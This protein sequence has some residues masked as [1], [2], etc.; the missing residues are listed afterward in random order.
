V[1]EESGAEVVLPVNK[2]EII[3]GRTDPV[4]GIHPEVDMT[5]HG[6][7]TGGVSR[8]HA[9]ITNDGGTWAITDLNSTNYTR[10]DG[11]KLDPS[12]A[13]PLHDGARI[14]L[15]RVAMVFRM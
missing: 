12:V 2:R 8:Q 11:V 15:G 13:R 9:R 6:G 5:P 3:I 14:Q 7:E 1:F 4:S 10:V